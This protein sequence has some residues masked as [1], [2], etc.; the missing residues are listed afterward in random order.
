[1]IA[2]LPAP[3]RALIVASLVVVALAACGRRGPLEPPPDPAAAAAQ[4][5][6]QALRQQRQGAS[7]PIF[8]E[9]E[10]EELPS[11]I[12]ASPIPTPSSRSGKRGYTIPKDPFVLD[13]L[14]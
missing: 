1:M 8:G 9:D 6:K 7:Q 11:N 2:S 10:P 5:Q 4:K 13:P 14:L 12:A 3:V